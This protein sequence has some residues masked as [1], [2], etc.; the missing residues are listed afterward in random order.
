L[1]AAAAVL[2]NDDRGWDTM[3]AELKLL[4]ASSPPVVEAISMAVAEALTA[5]GSPLPSLWLW[6]IT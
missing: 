1:I 2:W 4:H 3:A 6:S 5:G